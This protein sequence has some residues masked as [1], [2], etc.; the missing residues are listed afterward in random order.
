MPLIV[1]SCRYDNLKLAVA[2]VLKSRD[3]AET[4]RFVAL[5]S[6]HDVIDDHN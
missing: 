6:Q 2:R 4:E 3:R 5:R 1:P